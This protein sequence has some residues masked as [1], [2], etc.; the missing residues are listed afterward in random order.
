MKEHWRPAFFNRENLANWLKKGKKT[1][2]QKLIDKALEILRATTGTLL[3]GSRES[4][5]I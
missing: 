4:G 2:D 5:R 3:M 1:V